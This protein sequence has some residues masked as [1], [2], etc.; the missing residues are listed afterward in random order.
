[1]RSPLLRFLTNISHA[2][3]ISPCRYM[4]LPSYPPWFDSPNN[5]WW[6]QITKLLITLFS[7]S[8]FQE[9]PPPKY[10]MYFCYL[11]PDIYWLSQPHWVNWRKYYLR[12]SLRCKFLQFP[13]RVSF[14]VQKPSFARTLR[15]VWGRNPEF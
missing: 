7:P 12:C 5:F 1:L 11:I 9:V 15:E 10:C 6:V 13:L 8:S 2:F 14:K 3:L 4:P